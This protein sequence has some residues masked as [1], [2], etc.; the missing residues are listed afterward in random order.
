VRGSVRWPHQFSVSRAGDK[1]I[2]D[3]IRITPAG[4]FPIA[5]S[6]PEY[7]FDRNPN[8]I[9]HQEI[10]IEL[11]ADPKL[12]A[13]PQCAPNVVGILLS[14]VTLFNAL[15]DGCDAVAHEMQDSCH[16]HPQPTS[17]HHY[18]SLT[19]CLNSKPGGDGNS[20]LVGYGL[21]S[22]GIY[23]SYENGRQL[24]GADLDGCHGRAN[25]IDWDGRKV[26][27]YHYVATVGFP[28]TFGCMRGTYA[29]SLV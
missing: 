23:G 29:R 4:T 27:T 24:I 7:Q 11:P 19:N 9:M 1:C 28:H 18:H 10:R 21:D 3:S 17:V 20:P 2:L 22:F 15:N 14:G 8:R 13:Q 12:A 26:A 5:R 25:L 16:G 6:D